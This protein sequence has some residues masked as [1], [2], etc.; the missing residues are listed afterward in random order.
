MDNL[1]VT[2]LSS[3]TFNFNQGGNLPQRKGK[4]F[5]TAEECLKENGEHIWSESFDPNPNIS[6]C[7]MHYGEPCSWH[8]PKQICYHCPAERT[9]QITQQEKKEWVSK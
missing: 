3:G 2:N 5:T 8:N 1:I 9:L 6:C 4:Q 7:V